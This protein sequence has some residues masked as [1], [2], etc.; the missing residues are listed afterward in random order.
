MMIAFGAGSDTT[1]WRT[2][3]RQ[4]GQSEAMRVFGHDVDSLMPDLSAFTDEINALYDNIAATLPE[5][6]LMRRIYA[7]VIPY[8]QSDSTTISDRITTAT[9]RLRLTS[10]HARNRRG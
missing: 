1:E 6:Q 7:T 9:A 5:A 4:F 8:S 2:F 10:G 3:A